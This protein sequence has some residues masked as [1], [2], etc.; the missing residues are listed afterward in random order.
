MEYL[1]NSYG[2]PMEQ[3]ASNTPAAGWVLAEGAGAG[4]RAPGELAELKSLPQQAG[5]EGIAQRAGRGWKEEVST[6]AP[7]WVFDRAEDSLPDPNFPNE[8]ILVTV[9]VAK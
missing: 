3:H 7:A 1:W 2:V 4:W 8:P 6:K 9:S 5:V